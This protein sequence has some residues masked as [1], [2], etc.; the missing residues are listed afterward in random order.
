MSEEQQ[1]KQR[2]ASE[3]QKSLPLPDW[4]Q[5]ARLPDNKLTPEEW[6]S[7]RADAQK[8]A[9]RDE[10]VSDVYEWAILQRA[11]AASSVPSQPRG[12]AA[13]PFDVIGEFNKAVDRFE[14]TKTESSVFRQYYT[15]ANVNA[16]M[17]VVREAQGTAN[18][19]QQQM[20]TATELRQLR[21][22]AC[23]ANMKQF[24]NRALGTVLCKIY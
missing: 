24:Y 21:I 3:G 2:G 9:A 15:A 10:F 12:G 22:D 17:N 1:K 20:Q 8:A 5:Q 4:E 11:A 18:E 14:K 6:E 16:V 7:I 23:K 19:L 13:K